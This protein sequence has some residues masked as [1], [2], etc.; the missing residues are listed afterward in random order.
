MIHESQ[1][2]YTE[3]STEDERIDRRIKS[4]G[5]SLSPTYQLGRIPTHNKIEEFNRRSQEAL[6]R[7][8]K[9]FGKPSIK[10]ERYVDSYLRLH[11]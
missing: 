6:D 5:R 9:K 2:K 4:I 8:N 10:I 3:P 11:H 7:I 1:T